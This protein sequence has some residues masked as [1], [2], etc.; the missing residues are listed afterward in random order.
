MSYRISFL[1]SVVAEHK[2]FDEL[3][4]SFSEWIKQFLG[5]LHATS[6]I[7]TADQEPATCHNRVSYLLK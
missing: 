1:Q 7:S 3:L 4:L 5:K 6:E 2:Q